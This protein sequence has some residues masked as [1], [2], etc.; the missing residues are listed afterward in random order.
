MKNAAAYDCKESKKRFDEDA[1]FKKRAY[2]R[3]V[4]LQNGD[5]N[6]RKAWNLICDVSRKGIFSFFLVC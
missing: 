3:V 2:E 1:E 4:K 6:V 5:A